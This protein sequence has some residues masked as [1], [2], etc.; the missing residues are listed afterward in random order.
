MNRRCVCDISV[1]KKER[2]QRKIR[3]SKIGRSIEKEISPENLLAEFFKE[4]L[5]NGFH[6]Y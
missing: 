1:E 2:Y 5:E 4:F 6:V 3:E